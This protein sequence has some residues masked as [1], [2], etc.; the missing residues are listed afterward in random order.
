VSG[1]YAAIELLAANGL[2]SRAHAHVEAWT[3]FA[4]AGASII[5]TYGARHARSWLQ[6][7]AR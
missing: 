3:A 4:R 2:T 6:A 7:A 5:I 1:E